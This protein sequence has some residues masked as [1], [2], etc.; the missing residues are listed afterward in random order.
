MGTEIWTALS[1]VAVSG[2]TAFGSV[3]VAKA[4]RRTAEQEQRENFSTFTKALNEEIARVKADLVEQKEESVRQRRQ[5]GDLDAT[6]NYLRRRVG[7]LVSYIR[8]A[9]MEAPAPEEM[10]DRVRTY[11]DHIDV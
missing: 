9:G 10:P 5:I 11:L 3:W 7:V 1:G 4:G 6:V 2:L 8:K